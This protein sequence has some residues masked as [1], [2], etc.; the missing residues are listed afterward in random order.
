MVVD[1]KGDS[2]KATLGSLTGPA[3]INGNAIDI[4]LRSRDEGSMRLTGAI[5]QGSMSGDFTANDVKGTW[6]A[7]RPRSR[8]PGAAR[9]HRFE[10][11]E[12]PRVFSGAVPPALHI[13]PGDTVSTWT[14]DAAGI[15]GKGERRSLGGNPQTGPFYIEGA[16][17]GDVLTI[18]FVRI[19]PNRATALSGSSVAPTA[20]PPGT[21]TPPGAEGVTN[22]VLELDKGIARLARPP[23]ALA[24]YT[25]PFRPMLGTVGVAPP[26]MVFNSGYPGSFG[27]NMDYNRIREGVTLYLPVSDPGALL[28]VGDGH[29]AQGDAELTGGAIETSMDV[30]FTVGLIPDQ[31]LEMPRAEDAEFLMAMG[32]GGS[33]TE[34]FQLATANLMQWLRERYHLEPLE[35]APVLGTAT[36]Y[37]IAEVVDPMVNVVARIAKR[38]LAAIPTTRP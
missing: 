27:G 38:D 7:T 23:K 26:R 13:W 11:K 8:P 12:F 36:I 33:L 19:R 9:R 32:I 20:V 14:V 22:W 15:D 4:S 1:A 31:P 30:E 25:V 24:N 21:P 35:A 29:A 17:P 37:D 28:T 10:P 5:D 6:T 16:L 18:T 2:V 3:R 34:A